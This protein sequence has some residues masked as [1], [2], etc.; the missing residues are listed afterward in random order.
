MLKQNKIATREEIGLAQN[1]ND[2]FWTINLDMV[3]VYLK[4]RRLLGPGPGD[5]G[6]NVKVIKDK[7]IMMCK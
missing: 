4:R 5:S 6:R 1:D 2:Y 7:V 3:I